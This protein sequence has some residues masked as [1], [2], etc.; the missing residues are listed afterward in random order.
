MHSINQQTQHSFGICKRSFRAVLWLSLAILILACTKKP[1]NRTSDGWIRLFNGKNLDGWTVKFAGHALNENYN[2]T[3]RV[4]DGVLKVSYDQYRQFN[5]EFGHIFYHQP[6][7]HYRIR[8]E[9]RFLGNQVANA[10]D[11][12]F[13]N[14]GI[15]V[16]SQAPETMTIEQSFPVSIEVQLLGG[17]GVD[18]RPTGNLC[19]PG[20]H[21]VMNGQLITDHCIQSS[22]ATFPGDQWVTVE[23]EVHG[24]AR[25]RH[26][27]NGV[28]VLEYKQPQL[29]PG[30]P[31]AQKLIRDD[32]LLLDRGYIALQAE[33]HPVEFRKIE[34]LPLS[35]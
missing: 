33:S 22:S 19:T 7:S 31:D 5:N 12:A 30:D 18:P 26:S 27:I 14:S 1:E 35:E 2:H 13:R 3:F 16:H 24:N 10:P 32:A 34:L 15:M 11:W 23:V 25:V 8:A 17:N 28:T 4:E 6:Y 29:D 21:V 9:Y 20:T